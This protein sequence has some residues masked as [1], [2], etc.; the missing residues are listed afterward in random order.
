MHAINILLHYLLGFIL[1]SLKEH[2]FYPQCNYWGFPQPLLSLLVCLHR[3]SYL[4][5][6]MFTKSRAALYCWCSLGVGESLICWMFSM[7]RHYFCRLYPGVTEK[8]PE[9]LK[10]ISL[11]L[12]LCGLQR[13][14][15]VLRFILWVLLGLVLSLPFPGSAVSL[16]RSS[17]PGRQ[18]AVPSG[19]LG[20][21]QPLVQSSAHTSGLQPAPSLARRIPLLGGSVPSKGIW[22][23]SVI[24]P[25]KIR[26]K[27]T[28]PVLAVSL[29][30]QSSWQ[31]FP[32]FGV[33]GVSSFS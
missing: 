21:Q 12:I 4:H 32:V 5:L 16:R 1:L 11:I 10:Y 30:G 2:C 24:K 13:Q 22:E 27:D 31:T 14:N 19:R 26:S 28:S 9:R 3:F 18:K 15:E 25:S 29:E 6:C 33:I 20:A 8:Q 17:F 7:R 23:M